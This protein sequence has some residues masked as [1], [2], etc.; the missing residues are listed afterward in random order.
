MVSKTY[1]PD[2]IQEAILSLEAFLES[3]LWTKMGKPDIILNEA[4]YRKDIFRDEQ[5]F[6][7]YIRKHFDILL[8]EVSK[9]EKQNKV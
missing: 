2:T 4:W 7:I 1:E 9:L 5:Q 3:D 8:K 6:R